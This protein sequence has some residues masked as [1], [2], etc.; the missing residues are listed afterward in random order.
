MNR[1][2]VLLVA[3]SCLAIAALAG[4]PN[5]PPANSGAP[6]GSGGPS[7]S[8]APASTFRAG[9]VVDT[10]GID[11]RS[12]NAAANEGRKKAE[13]DL[14][15]NDQSYS[16]IQSK[17]KADYKTNL[18]QFASQGYN[19]VIAVGQNMEDALKEVAPQF[20]NVKFAIVDGAAPDGVN[21][22]A[23]LKFRE[24]QGTFLAGF[25]AASM[26]KT[27]K[28]GF[29]GGEEIDLI[30]KFE[31]GYRA[32]AKTA[33]FD[34]DKQVLRAYTNNWDDVTKGRTQ[35][36][37]LYSN[38]VDIIFAAAGKGGLGVIEAARGKGPGFYAIGVDQDQDGIAPGRV[39][40]S[41]VKHVDTAVFDTT[42]RAKEGKFAPGTVTYDLKQGGMDLSEMKYTRKDIPAP[43]LDKLAK[44]RKLVEDGT[45][46]PPT[47]LEA[48]KTFNPPTL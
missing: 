33:G 38:G 11:D 22:T 41:V 36:E 7:T 34:P 12:F 13:A 35:A 5:P 30:K 3:L 4:C 15:M 37:Q 23:S 31:A 26:S 48:V 19:L 16:L 44:L 17:A 24:E 40:T 27:K 14:G 9:L 32:G 39:L 42:K 47:T 1:S 6:G 20:P 43:I 10:G 46:A 45:V 8:G 29:V 28:I 18:T 25:L 21:N 2:H